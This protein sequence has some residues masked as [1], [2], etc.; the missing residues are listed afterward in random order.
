MTNPPTAGQNASAKE[1]LAK[2]DGILDSF[3]QQLDLPPLQANNEACA[4][5]RMTREQLQK[6]TPE[7]CG[8]GSFLLRRYA[9]YV[10]R[11]MNRE[12]AK[13]NFIV[14]A[15]R[16]TVAHEVGQHRAPSAEE[17]R[18]LAIHGNVHAAALEGWRQFHQARADQLAFQAKTIG[19]MAHSL[20]ELQQTKRRQRAS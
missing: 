15:L 8:E 6:L 13:V 2:L 10:Q 14:S 11:A 1:W 3:E 5:L 7:E 18:E 4:F 20:D 12:I 16:K 17:R 19:D 9:Y